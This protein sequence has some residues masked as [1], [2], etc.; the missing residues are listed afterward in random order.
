MEHQQVCWNLNLLFFIRIKLILDVDIIFNK[1]LVYIIE[2]IYY[3]MGTPTG[4]L[5]SRNMF[6]HIKL[7][8]NADIIFN[9][10][11]GYIIEYICY[12][13]GTPTGL[14]ETQLIIS[15][16]YKTY[17]GCWY[18]F[19]K[20]IGL[21]NRIHILLYWNINKSGWISNYYFLYVQQ[22]IL[23]LILFLQIYWFT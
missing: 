8:L 9:K 3:F 21:H 20:S 5:E 4:L 10:L 15:H 13:I 11:L 12:C 7:I 16:T 19:Y 14:L 1:L 22:F 2:Y 17:F 18:Y 6:I 23:M